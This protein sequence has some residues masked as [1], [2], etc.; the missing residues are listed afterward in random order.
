MKTRKLLWLLASAAV[1]APIA[2]T[3]MPQP[4]VKVVNNVEEVP[5]RATTIRRAALPASSPACC[6]VRP[7]WV[8]VKAGARLAAGALWKCADRDAV[9]ELDGTW[10]TTAGSEFATPRS[11]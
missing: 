5:V 2:T 10:I 8:A 4:N 9:T 3:V 1:L 6:P 7:G 11:T